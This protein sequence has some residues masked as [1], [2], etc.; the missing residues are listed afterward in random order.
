M[1]G[2]TC[3]IRG[4]HNSKGRVLTMSCPLP[5]GDVGKAVFNEFLKIAL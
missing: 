4:L 5:T 2:T 1:L 3:W